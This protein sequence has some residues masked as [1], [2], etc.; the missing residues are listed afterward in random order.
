[1]VLLSDIGGQFEVEHKTQQLITAIG[2]TIDCNG[3]SWQLGASAGIAIPS[4]PNLTVSCALK[5]ADNAMYRA[6]RSGGNCFTV[7]HPGS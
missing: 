1:M 5:A 6:K 3:T 4:G 2:Q 7:Q